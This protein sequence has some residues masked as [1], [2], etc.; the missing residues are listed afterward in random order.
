MSIVNWGGRPRAF[1]P[2]KTALKGSSIARIDRAITTVA[3]TRE[4]YSESNQGYRVEAVPHVVGGRL[5]GIQYWSG[6]DGDAV[7]ERPLVAAWR[8]DFTTKTALGSPEWAEMADLPPEERGQ[9][10]SLATVF[11]QV[12]TDHRESVALKRIVAPQAGETNQGFWTIKRRDGTEWQS[13][14]SHRTVEESIGG[15]THLVGLGL[16]QR[17]QTQP[18]SEPEPFVLLE[19]RLIEASS[20]PGEYQA[21]VDLDSLTLV[22]WRH[23]TTPPDRIAW[24]RIAT[25][26]EPAVHPDDRPVMLAMANG[27]SKSSTTGSLRVRGVDGEWVRISA[28]ADLV[29]VDRNVTA[30]L[31]RF[32]I[33]S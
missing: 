10:A 27:L 6:H 19:H 23:G 29:P 20:T 5:H 1:L 9:A 22:R 18:D 7:P 28:R 2:V 32:T 26:P 14:W 21:I 8:V 4:P 13:H 3:E 12:T 11:A 24:R 16:S 33:E 25:E 17:V 31:V 30:A 15:E